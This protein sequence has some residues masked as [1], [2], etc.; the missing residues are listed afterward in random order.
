MSYFLNP[1]AWWWLWLVPILIILYFLKLKREERIFPTTMLWHRTIEDLRVNTPF[2]RLKNNLLLFLQLLLL[3]LLIASLTRPFWSEEW[4]PGKHIIVLL[5]QSASMGTQEAD[6]QTRLDKAKVLIGK[7]IGDLS[8]QDRMML[9]GFH[10]RVQILAPFTEMKPL[11]KE[12]LSKATVTHNTTNLE[13][14][15]KLAHAMAAKLSSAKIY[16]VT[17]GAISNIN[18]VMQALYAGFEQKQGMVQPEFFLIGTASSNVAILNL[19]VKPRFD[20]TCQVF[21]RLQNTGNDPVKG[22]IE[23]SCAGKLL[24]EENKLLEFNPKDVH[25]VLWDHIPMQE[26][27]LELRFQATQGQDCLETD[28]IAYYSLGSLEKFQVG[29]ALQNPFL[30]KVFQAQDI[31]ICKIAD[32]DFAKPQGIFNYDLVVVDHT[33]EN[34]T[35]PPGNY[36]FFNSIPTLPKLEKAGDLVSKARAGQKLLIGDQH[37]VHPMLRF[38]DLRKL[39]IAKAM[40]LTL[41]PETIS[42]L[43][44]EDQPI[45]AL[46]TQSEST[47]LII[48]FDLWQSDWP[49][50][51]SFPIF[52]SNALEWFQQQRPSYNKTTGQPLK[53]QLP[54]EI[55]KVQFLQPT[56]MENE[57]LIEPGQDIVLGTADFVG[58]YEVKAQPNF[59][60]SIAV[61]LFSLEESTITP[62]QE[63][64]IGKSNVA[65]NTPK[66]M[67]QELWSLFVLV[68]LAVMLLEW[69]VYH[70]GSLKFWDKIVFKKGF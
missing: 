40:K 11:L 4:I 35:Q 34:A 38:V 10:S 13:E 16:V 60:R 68:A 47:Y 37:D 28:N 24:S 62:A 39:N 31:E 52:I 29:L 1:A 59:T 21:A 3:L 63:V 27:R 58:F 12:A 18:E 69:Y 14:A 2:Q 33:I 61:N 44:A 54:R 53:L 26:S 50:Q 57:V 20:Q 55:T 30:L 49:L 6:G 7:I 25:G 32:T 65:Q 23:L 67:N 45:I 41:P 51:L 15:L 70:R 36:I 56:N 9:A 22:I 66:L 48:G 5:D 17:D 19:Q 46:L 64:H 8:E 42:L 43:E